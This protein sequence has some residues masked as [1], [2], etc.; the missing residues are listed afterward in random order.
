MGGLLAIGEMVESG[1]I[2]PASAATIKASNL[3]DAAREEAEEQFQAGIAE[4][5]P[6]PTAT[7]AVDQMADSNTR[8]TAG[9]APVKGKGKGKGKRGG[10]SPYNGE[11]RGGN[12]ARGR[13]VL[14]K[15]YSGLG[16][17]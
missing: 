5:D 7:V 2:E 13:S 12:A 10:G 14:D 17:S 3:A 9:G 6:S 11:R 16:G 4:P 8:E 1:F 15:E